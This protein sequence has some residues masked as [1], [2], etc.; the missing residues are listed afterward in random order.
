M[1]INKNIYLYI[2]IL[3]TSSFIA[4]CT[5]KEDISV[6]PKK[7]EKDI[8]EFAINNNYP[9]VIHLYSDTVYNISTVF[10]RFD[11]EQL[12]IDAGTLIKIGKFD[13]NAQSGSTLGGIFIGP[14]GSIIANGTAQKPIIFT[15]SAPTG[16]QG[17]NW[18]GIYIKG[19]SFNNG[20]GTLGNASDFSCSLKYVRIEFVRKHTSKLCQITI[21][22]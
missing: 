19:K 2:A 12:I 21:G 15:S 10:N 6:E 13:K 7:P 20:G 14:G 18:Q 8:L 11:G 3:F 1:K 16:L 17:T 4:S 22:F 9:K 5:K